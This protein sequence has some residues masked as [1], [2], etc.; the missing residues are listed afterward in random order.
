MFVSLA[1]T[2][3]HVEKIDVDSCDASWYRERPPIASS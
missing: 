3:R 1:S 2:Q